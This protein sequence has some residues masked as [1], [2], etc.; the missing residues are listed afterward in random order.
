MGLGQALEGGGQNI[1]CFIEWTLNNTTFQR[2]QTLE[3]RY[4]VYRYLLHV[5]K[6]LLWGQKTVGQ[7]EV[8]RFLLLTYNGFTPILGSRFWSRNIPKFMSF[9]CIRPLRAF[10]EA[11]LIFLTSVTSVMMSLSLSLTTDCWCLPWNQDI[12]LASASITSTITSTNTSTSTSCCS[13][14]FSALYVVTAGSWWLIHHTAVIRIDKEQLKHVSGKDLKLHI[15]FGTRQIGRQTD[16]QAAILSY[17]Q[18]DRQAD[19]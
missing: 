1:D 3:L 19:Y 9:T 16:R 8:N 7:F 15:S 13:G 18:A 6:T 4:L 14:N 5:K 2:G 11:W 10:C 12:L 17:R